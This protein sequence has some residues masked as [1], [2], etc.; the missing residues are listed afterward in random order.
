M[1]YPPEYDEAWEA[2]I[3]KGTYWGLAP[4]H[5]GC[6]ENG[7]KGALEAAARIIENGGGA[8]QIRALAIYTEDE[9]D[10]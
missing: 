6:F 10:A 2:M 9:D 1:G 4:I 7:W 3:A 8:E 5:H